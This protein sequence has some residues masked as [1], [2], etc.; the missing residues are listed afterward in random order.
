MKFFSKLS[1]CINYISFLKL[2]LWPNKF[3]NLIVLNKKNELKLQSINSTYMNLLIKLILCICCFYRCFLS[4][5]TALYLKQVVVLKGCRSS[6]KSETLKDL[7][8]ALGNYVLPVNCSEN[9]NL[10][11]MVQI[12]SGLAKVII[13]CVSKIYWNIMELYFLH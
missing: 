13:W 3:A 5:T 4:L 11:S 2:L 6:G 8:V 12:M 1:L 10:K 9:L 7:G